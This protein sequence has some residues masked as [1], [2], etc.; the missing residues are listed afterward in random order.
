MVALLIFIILIFYI[1]RSSSDRPRILIISLGLPTLIPAVT[2]GYY[3][4]FVIIIA[5]FIIIDPTFLDHL[6]DVPSNSVTRVHKGLNNF[7]NYLLITVIAISLAP[8]P[9]VMQRGRNSIALESFSS[10]W[11]VVLIATLCMQIYAWWILRGS[12]K[13]L[14]QPAL[15]AESGPRD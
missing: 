10:I 9:F 13:F 7:Y 4:N 15:I 12:S 2:Y 1:F 3:S 14:L 11:L 8:I 5:T 6:K